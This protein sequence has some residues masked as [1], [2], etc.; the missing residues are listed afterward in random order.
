MTRACS[1]LRLDT[2]FACSARRAL[3]K[4]AFAILKVGDLQ[5]A[6]PPNLWHVELDHLNISVAPLVFRKHAVI[7]FDDSGE[8]GIVQEIADAFGSFRFRDLRKWDVS[9]DYVIRNPSKRHFLDLD[10]NY[11]VLKEN[12]RIVKLHWTEVI[13]FMKLFS[14]A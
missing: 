5:R 7:L 11:S 4:Q 14:T 10:G 8:F 2:R 13:L 12:N 9:F 1:K 6:I 3:S